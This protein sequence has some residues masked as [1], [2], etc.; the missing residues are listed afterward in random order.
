[1]HWMAGERE[2]RRRKRRAHDGTEYVAA[3]GWERVSGR[4]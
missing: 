2:G 4:R 1:M 3:T